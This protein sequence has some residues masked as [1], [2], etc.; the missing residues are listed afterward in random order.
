MAEELVRVQVDAA[1]VAVPEIEVA[2]EHQ[3]LML[4]QVVERARANVV[5]SGHSRTAQ[6]GFTN[7]GRP[8]TIVAATPP[9][10]A[11][12]S[13]GVFFERERSADACTDTCRS[14]ARIVTSAG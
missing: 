2:V 5:E 4:L 7:T 3:H 11:H 8:P 1:V 9:R 14:G 12:P 13:N 10:S 6:S